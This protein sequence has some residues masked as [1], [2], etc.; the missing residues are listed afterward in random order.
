MAA[1]LKD[2]GKKH[3]VDEAQLEEGKEPES[4]LEVKINQYFGI[5]GHRNHL[6]WFL[7]L[8]FYG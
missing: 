5:F 6:L 1:Y 8:S 3:G 2:Y 7:S 4:N